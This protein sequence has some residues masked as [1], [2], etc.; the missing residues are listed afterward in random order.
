MRKLLVEWDTTLLIHDVP[1][2]VRCFGTREED[3]QGRPQYGFAMHDAATREDLT[4]YAGRPRTLAM[5]IHMLISLG[6]ARE[7]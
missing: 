2:H 3:A 6:R 7:V 4:A 5:G 1:R